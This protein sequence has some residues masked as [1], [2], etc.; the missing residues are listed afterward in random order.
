M[1]LG[2]TENAK[3]FPL[4]VHRASGRLGHLAPPP[5][6]MGAGWGV[7]E[8]LGSSVTG[9]GRVLIRRVSSALLADGKV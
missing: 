6:K 4:T 7:R 2:G 3:V 9:R 5:S 8:G 1:G